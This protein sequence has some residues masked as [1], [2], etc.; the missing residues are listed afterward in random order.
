MGSPGLHSF[1]VPN[2]TLGDTRAHMRPVREIADEKY[3]EA[4]V[5]NTALIIGGAALLLIAPVVA[6]IAWFAISAA[7][8][9]NG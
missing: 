4:S 5:M 7:R 3:P 9:N 6:V 1:A 8:K 2:W